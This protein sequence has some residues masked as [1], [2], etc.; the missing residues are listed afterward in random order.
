MRIR[1]AIVVSVVSWCI[2]PLFSAAA[3]PNVELT[4]RLQRLET[5]T[6]AL[7]TELQWL[8]EN[9]VRLPEVTATSPTWRRPIQRQ[10]PNRRRISPGARFSRR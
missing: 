5:E 3:D 1:L 9:P 2:A 8:R 10:R 7:R 6:Q 4:Q